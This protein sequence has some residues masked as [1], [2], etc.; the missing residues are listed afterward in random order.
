M[1]RRWR[2]V[3][4]PLHITAALCTVYLL[5]Y[6]MDLYII[7]LGIPVPEGIGRIR[8]PILV[9][10][11][12]LYGFYRVRVFHPFYN[13]KYWQWLC[14]SPW[15]IDKPLPQGPVHLI[16][17]DVV[18]LAVLTLC[19]YSNIPFF[20]AVPVVA[21][22]IVYLVMIFLAFEAEQ[23]AFTILFLFLAPFAFYPFANLYVTSLVLILLYALCCVGF[24]RSF[25]DF[26]WNTKYWKGDVVEEFKKQAVKQNVL[27]WPF[28]FLNIYEAPRISY[29]GAFLLSLLLTW[30][31]HV[32]R[33][34][35]DEP[36]NI[37]LLALLALLVAFIRTL[38]YAAEYRP[39]ISLTGRIFTGRLIIPRYDKIYI[40]P[41]CI[42]LV[43]IPLPLL[44]HRY[45]LITAWNLEICFFLIFFLAFSLPPTLNKWRLTGAYRIGKHVQS[46]RPRPPSP[47]DQALAE[48]FAVKLWRKGVVKDV[49]KHL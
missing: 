49:G 37:S 18:I 31:L 1:S 5:T 6:L 41:L 19:A 14:L 44:L 36:Y 22:L 26:P 2:K 9:L 47:Q 42:L 11:S 32:I 33:W 21:F 27:G 16:W 17:V 8:I 10:A 35:I 13:S 28:K 25:K 29:F 4:P 15:S 24:Y 38:V 3:L 34:A 48:F 39:P 46:L 20:T 23:I 43:G 45:G 30:W 40:A 7:R 12:A